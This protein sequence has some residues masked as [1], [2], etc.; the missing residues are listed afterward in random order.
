MNFALFKDKEDYKDAQTA[1]EF[2][3]RDFSHVVEEITRLYPSVGIGDTATD[4]AICN[5][6]YKLIHS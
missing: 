2:A 4:E 6:V 5:E 3:V 1:L